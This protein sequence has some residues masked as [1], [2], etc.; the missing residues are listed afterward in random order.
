MHQFF[1]ARPRSEA[2]PGRPGFHFFAN[3][4]GVIGS[5]FWELSVGTQPNCSRR[6][7]PSPRTM[8]IYRPSDCRASAWKVGLPAIDPNYFPSSRVKFW[9]LVS[10]KRPNDSAARRL[11][12]INNG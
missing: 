12:A 4:G 11:T 6:G 5:F 7:P 3:S 1:E 8:L 2:A 9:L 10:G